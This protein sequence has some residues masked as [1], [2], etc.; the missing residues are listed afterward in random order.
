MPI[1][2][3]AD[4]FNWAK[5]IVL[6]LWSRWSVLVS[7]VLGFTHHNFEHILEVS[8]VLTEDYAAV[9]FVLK[10]LEVNAVLDYTVQGQSIFH[11][12]DLVVLTHENGCW[13][14]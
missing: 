8:H 6:L 1:H 11:G 4:I 3:V 7:D 9:V 2:G 14:G 12:G 13:D 5:S 10:D